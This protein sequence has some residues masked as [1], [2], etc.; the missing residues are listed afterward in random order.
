ML[1]VVS[2]INRHESWISPNGVLSW[3]Q[4]YPNLLDKP[5]HSVRAALIP[6][7]TPGV[8]SAFQEVIESGH[9]LE[10]VRIGTCPLWTNTGRT[11]FLV[12]MRPAW[13]ASLCRGVPLAGIS[14]PACSRRG[15]NS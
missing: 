11:T 13:P 4:R 6:S 12:A 2:K 9:V 8:P 10:S 14:T 15:R 7:S 5:G 3:Y 1:Y